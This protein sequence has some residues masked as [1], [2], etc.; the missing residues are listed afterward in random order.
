MMIMGI[1]QITVIKEMGS[2]GWN[3]LARV[4]PTPRSVRAC[5]EPEISHVRV[6]TPWK[7]SDT[8]NHD[9]CFTFPQR[10]GLLTYHCLFQ[11]A[12]LNVIKLPKFHSRGAVKP[13]ME[14][15][16]HS[17][18]WNWL[19][20]PASEVHLSI[21]GTFAAGVPPGSDSKLEVTC[22]DLNFSSFSSLPPAHLSPIFPRI[23]L[24]PLH[25]FRVVVAVWEN[26]TTL[27]LWRLPKRVVLLA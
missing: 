23:L 11:S 4:F 5:C 6:L 8:T 9:F 13:R 25:P 24:H 3:Q 26:V 18:M 16:S 22:K 2:G 15:S 14:V 10:I 19:T 17:F 1:L 12:C 20:S 21:Q 7:L 27:R